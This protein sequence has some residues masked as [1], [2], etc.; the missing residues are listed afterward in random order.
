M[1]I[2]TFNNKGEEYHEEYETIEEATDRVQSLYAKDER[3]LDSNPSGDWL[4]LQGINARMPNKGQAMKEMTGMATIVNTVVNNRR[5]KK[6]K[7]RKAEWQKA[8][9]KL[10]DNFDRLDNPLEMYELEKDDL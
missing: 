1:I 2:L 3:I 6:R 4:K 10:R 9:K 5:K 8:K 7:I